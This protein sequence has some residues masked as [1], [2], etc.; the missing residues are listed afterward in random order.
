VIFAASVLGDV[1]RGPMVGNEQAFVRAS[2]WIGRRPEQLDR[3]EALARLGAR[4]LVSHAP[5]EPKDLA[6]WA[7][8]TLG[9][10]RTAL[11]TRTNTERESAP[12]PPPRLLGAFDELLHGWA[13]RELFTGPHTSKAI[14]G[15][16]FR[17]VALVNGRI[18]GTWG[19]PN[20]TPT[21]TI[22]QAI[23]IRAITALNADA[24]AV[25]DFFGFPYRGTTVTNAY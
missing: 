8:I 14:S 2:D 22:F 9:D 4:Y 16:T 5:A 1:I 7:G 21:I 6:K 25:I 18:V 17:P 10:A 23:P 3:G 19:L 12:L 15:G 20:G 13:S 11:A 24:R